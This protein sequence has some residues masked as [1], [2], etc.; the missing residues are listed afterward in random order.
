MPTRWSVPWPLAVAGG[1]AA[2]LAA[3]GLMF[4]LRLVAQVR[5]IPERLLE[6]LLLFV[7]PD[8]FEAGLQR[9]GFD[10]KRYGLIGATIGMLAVLVIL[11]AFA[12]RS[13]WSTAA[14]T[15]VGLGL[16]LFVMVVVMPL[17]NAG[18]FGVEIVGGTRSAILG[19][20]SAGL[21]YAGVLALVSYAVERWPR[22]RSEPRQTSRRALVS[23]LGASLASVVGTYLV[24]LT[25]PRQ[26]L[27]SVRV[28][29]PQEPVP[30]GGIDRPQPHPEV[31]NTPSSLAAADDT[32]Q[33]GAPAQ[34][35]R[36]SDLPQ[37]PPSRQLQRDQDGAL[38]PSGRRQGELAPMLT[39]TDDFYVVTKN[40]A[41]DPVIRPDEWR[42]RIDGEVLR[43]L[44]TEYR[45]LRNLPWVEITKTL[46]CISNFVAKCEM[47]PFGCDL[48]GTARW[49]GVRLRD[50]LELAGGVRPGAQYLATISA[51][52][53]T[54]ALPIDVA[55][56]PQTLLV[57]EM[58]GQV[59]PREH[60]YPARVLVP[61][62][63]GMKNA[64]WV[65]ALRPVTREFVDWYGQR[66]WTRAGVIK[67]MTRID[68]PAPN[69]VLMPGEHRLA[70]IAYAGNRDIERV[71]Y[72]TDGGMTWEDARFIDARGIGTDVWLRW[73]GTFS[74]DPD[75]QVTLM[76]R[77]TDG[78]GQVQQEA[79]SLPQPDGGAG[80][81]AINVQ[82]GA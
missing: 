3:A 46:E 27:T 29:D 6:A 22:R 21:V 54:T 79:F 42:L 25:G 68:T 8:V 77:A 53:F 57:Y 11:G 4:L 61:G 10:A 20:L 12:L 76:S 50:L 73:E 40:A 59:L 1:V 2:S 55:M 51:D 18:P 24:V 16:W 9:F 82:A 33:G 37:P 71:E 28:L 74:V 36:E 49:R 44:E 13:R 78:T 67:T 39:Q 41:G 32:S 31:V 34:A 5:T 35:T 70:G 45:S 64:K 47:V 66:N 14:L 60:G 23:L 65:V 30:S 80:W 69:A 17:T 56:D 26:T 52:E 7:P 38:M 72:S 48:I 58:N 19:N 75:A 81:H 43:P 63:Y 15:V 62:R